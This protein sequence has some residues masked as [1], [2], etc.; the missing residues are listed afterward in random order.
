MEQGARR[1]LAADL[2]SAY[3]VQI[4]NY[5]E[6]KF[7]FGCLVGCISGLTAAQVTSFNINYDTL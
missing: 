1:F 7:N 5:R 4:F 2:K 6:T 3:K